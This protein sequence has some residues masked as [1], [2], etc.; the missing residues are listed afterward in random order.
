MKLLDEFSSCFSET[1]GFCSYVEHCISLSDNFEPKRLREYRMAEVLK[2]E[3]Q[4][5]IEEL[6]K[7]GFISHFTS[8][9]ASAIVL[10]LKG[11]DGQGGVRL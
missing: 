6:L 3:I 11:P 7:N 4:R 8:A 1:A 5:Q 10:P 9:M 2:P